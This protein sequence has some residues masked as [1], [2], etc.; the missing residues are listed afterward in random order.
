MTRRSRG[1]RLTRLHAPTHHRCP[2]CTNMF[3]VVADGRTTPA[4][5]GHMAINATWPSCGA[6]AG[7][8]ARKN[9]TIRERNV[10]LFILILLWQVVFVVAS[11]YFSA[12]AATITQACGRAYPSIGRKRDDG[13]V[14][15]S[16]D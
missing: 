7:Y 16:G 11:P 2:S 3:Q 13:C 4:A 10:C 5:A 14:P 15:Q 8:P 12:C 1:G 6:L 9:S